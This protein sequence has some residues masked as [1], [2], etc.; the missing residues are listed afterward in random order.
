MCLIWLLNLHIYSVI[1]PISN[2]GAFVFLEAPLAGT[3]PMKSCI[4][5]LED[6]EAKT[7]LLLF[8]FSKLIIEGAQMPAGRKKEIHFASRSLIASKIV[9]RDIF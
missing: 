1:S 6:L 3:A 8:V 5:L 7:T 9:S 2:F 4:S